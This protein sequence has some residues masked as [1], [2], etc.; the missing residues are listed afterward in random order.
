MRFYPGDFQLFNVSVAASNA[1]GLFWKYD[2]F[3]MA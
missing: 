3:A 1:T 2:S